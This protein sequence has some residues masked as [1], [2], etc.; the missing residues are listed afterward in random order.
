MSKPALRLLAQPLP[1]AEAEPTTISLF[2]AIAPGKLVELSGNGAVARTTAAVSLLCSVQR[3]GETAAWIQPRHGTLFPPDLHHSGVDL[4][5]LAVIHVPKENG[6]AGLCRAA[7]LL[8]RSGAFGLVILDLDAMPPPRGTAWQGRL[9]GL[10]RQHHT[11]VV[12]I[13]DTPANK[14]SLGP[15][16]TL[17]IEPQRTPPH[18]V[19]KSKGTVFTFL[20]ST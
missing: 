16:I 20:L 10:A 3:T 9:L 5:A 12:M 18:I 14:D 17:R 19:L 15:L 1:E 4:D 6:T 13:T 7:E 8:L 11:R 2:E